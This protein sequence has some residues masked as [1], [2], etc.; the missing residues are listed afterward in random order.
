M[1]SAFV[2]LGL[3]IL[4]IGIYLGLAPAADRYAS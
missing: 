3:S 2:R 1:I 4:L